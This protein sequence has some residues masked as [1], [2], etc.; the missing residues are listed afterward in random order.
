MVLDETVVQELASM[1]KQSWAMMNREGG[2]HLQLR[3]SI[4]AVPTELLRVTYATA[5]TLQKLAQYGENQKK[6]VE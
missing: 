2:A 3:Q 6:C 1:A 4:E 5:T